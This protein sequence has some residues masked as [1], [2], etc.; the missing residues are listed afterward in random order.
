MAGLRSQTDGLLL[1][2]L[3]L[4]AETI[5]PSCIEKGCG[6]DDVPHVPLSVDTCGQ[7]FARSAATALALTSTSR[8]FHFSEFAAY[9]QLLKTLNHH[10]N[11]THGDN[12]Q[13]R[14]TLLAP[15][16][17]SVSVAVVY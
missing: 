11:E 6:G 3:V 12:A 14:W 15:S 7:E 13:A 1:P 4:L 16:R 2:L 17:L 10:T 9:W 8:V 5:P